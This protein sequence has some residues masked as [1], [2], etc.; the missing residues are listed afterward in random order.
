MPTLAQRGGGRIAPTH[1]QPRDYKVV[2]SPG[3]G[4]LLSKKTK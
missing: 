4:A 3:P 2:G 1:S